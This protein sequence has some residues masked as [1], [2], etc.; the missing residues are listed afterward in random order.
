MDFSNGMPPQLAGLFAGEDQAS[1]MANQQRNRES[2]LEQILASQQNR[3]FAAEKQP[4]TLQQLQGQIK[5]Q[6]L[7]NDALQFTNNVDQQYGVPAAVAAKQENDRRI[8]L[9]NNRSEY[10]ELDDI[11]G[12]AAAS[13]PAAPAVVTHYLKRIGAPTELIDVVQKSTPEEIAQRFREMGRAKMYGTASLYQKEQAGERANTGANDRALLRAGVEKYKAELQSMTQLQIAQ[14]RA[15]LN[16]GGPNSHR[17]EKTYAAEANY[18]QREALEET[19][20]EKRKQKLAL[21]EYYRELDIRQR[22]AGKLDQPGL[23]Q[24][25]VT[26][27]NSLIQRTPEDRTPAAPPNPVVPPPAAGKEAPPLQGNDPLGIRKK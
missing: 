1:Q 19:D 27:K 26:G 16:G 20:P 22:L 8:K 24:N 6:G 15:K 25:P 23:S 9:G 2:I 13:G 17:P 21:H 11:A 4:L 3:Q 12:L 14:L 5:H 18:W 7:Q 10:E